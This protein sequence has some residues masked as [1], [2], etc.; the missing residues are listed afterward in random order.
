M[1]CQSCCHRRSTLLPLSMVDWSGEGHSQCLMC[2]HKIEHG[3]F[4][5]KVALQVRGV[6]GIRQCFTHQATM[7]LAGGQVVTFNRRR[8]D[9]LSAQHLCDDFR[10][11]KNDTPTDFNHPSPCTMFIDLHIQQCRV[12]Q[13]PSGWAWL[14]WP[15]SAR[16]RFRRT[17]VRNECFNIRRQ[18]VTRKQWWAAIR[19]GLKCGQ[20]CRSFLRAALVGEMMDH[21]HMTWQSDSSPD[22]GITNIAG[23]VRLQVCLF[24]LTKVQS[25]SICACVTCNPRMKWVLTAAAC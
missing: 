2:T 15:M 9:L 4:Q 3:V 17:V 11:T 25:S 16:E 10:R 18:L 23:V 8:V 14:T 7:A 22:P 1:I 19:S 12:Q 13:P 24:F 5:V 20:E 21:T 6:L